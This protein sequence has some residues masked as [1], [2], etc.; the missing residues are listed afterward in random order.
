MIAITTTAVNRSTLTLVRMTEGRV[1]PSDLSHTLSYLEFKV[2]GTF[3][4]NHLS[5]YL[6]ASMHAHI[7][8]RLLLDCT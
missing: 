7:Q 8:M 3:N 1:P 4:Y 2:I 6:I 5:L